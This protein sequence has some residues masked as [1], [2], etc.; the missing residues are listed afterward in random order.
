MEQL[1]RQRRYLGMTQH[2]LAKV[3]NVAPWKI[4]FA[5][6]GRA[7]LTADE[8]ERVKVALAKQAAEIGDSVAA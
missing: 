4:T 2:E 1:K 8:I 3:A 5:E 7:E 6:T